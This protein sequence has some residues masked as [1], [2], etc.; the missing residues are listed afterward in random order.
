MTIQDRDLSWYAV[1]TRVRYENVAS[2]VLEQKDYE[3][4]FP[5]YE[6]KR[7]WSDRQKTI[8]L[9]L[10]PGY[11]FCKFNPSARLP[12]LCT[13]GVI[14]IVGNGS[15]PTPIDHEEVEA[16]QRI[17]NSGLQAEPAPFDVEGQFV[18]IE[19]GPLTGLE[20]MVIN[21][22]NSC[23]L[24]VTVTL[25]QRSVSAEIDRSWVRVLPQSQV[26]MAG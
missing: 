12:I 26:R 16:I 2:A 6:S 24:I 10:F 13:A 22:K 23:R 5:K 7:A 19:K 18:S 11:I 1:H 25:L 9:P 21:A 14:S 20:G 17:V 8:E 15:G 3:V 4:F